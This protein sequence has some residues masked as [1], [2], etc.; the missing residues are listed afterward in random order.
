M[1]YRWISFTTD[2][3]LADGFVAACH[4]VLATLAPEARVIDITHQVPPQHVRR[5]AVALAQTVPYLPEAVHV[6]VVDPGVGTRRRGVVVSA[7]QGVLVGP[8][9]G[10]L[11][12]A[13][14]A[15]GGVHAAY[16]LAASAYRLS[17][18]SATFH[19]RDIFAPAAAHL[20]RGIAPEEFGPAVDDLVQLPEQPVTARPHQL[21]AEVLTV[22]GFGNVSL[23]ASAAD[24]NTA[25]FPGPVRVRCGEKV[26]P[27]SL[28]RTFADVPTGAA[29]LLIDSSGRPAIAINGG[30][31][32][33]A[34]AIHNRTAPISCDIT[35]ASEPEFDGELR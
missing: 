29:V 21:R 22:D 34:L 32:A 26:L 8:D 3:G 18:T 33:D 9:N 19:G 23:A 25:A 15:L 28:G 12:P 4:G 35:P 24:L 16:E 31:A 30:S 5:G 2:Y 14:D 27:A 10:L 20:A 11:L 17:T 1:R 13:A 7:A 6:A